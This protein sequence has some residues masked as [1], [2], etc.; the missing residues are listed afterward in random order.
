[1]GA[2][3]AQDWQ[4][5][6]ASVLEWWRDAGVDMLVDD[7]PRDWM[8]RPAPRP[9]GA[10]DAAAV[11]V[12]PPITPETLPDTLDAFVAWRLSDAAPEADWM[13]P[14]IGPSGPPDAEWAVLVDM[15][16]AEDRD[17]LVGGPA[18]RLLDRMLLAVGLSRSMVYLASLAVARPVTGQIPPEQL[19]R[20]LE[21]ARRHLALVSPQKL[22]LVGQ[23][24]SRVVP[25]L[26]GSF[27][28]NSVTVVNQFG[29]NCGVIAV[30]H[31]R[32]FCDHP[33]VKAEAWR[34]MLLLH[35]GESQ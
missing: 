32:F 24:T 7:A 9:E 21:L 30:R 29:P 26:D 18:G 11:A 4:K 33:A 27:S 34:Q 16:E 19:P 12:A 2:E 13:A 23:A 14:R 20:L 28:G 5:G 3:A 22:L 31:P 35:R 6:A 8:A 1:M 17:T 10:A 25:E 15:P